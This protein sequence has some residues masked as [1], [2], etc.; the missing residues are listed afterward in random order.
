MNKNNEK[1]KVQEKDI[2]VSYND[3]LKMQ[4]ESEK[5]FEA[6]FGDVMKMTERF[7]F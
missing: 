5:L 6:Y 3:V 1:E 4:K 7:G 2:K